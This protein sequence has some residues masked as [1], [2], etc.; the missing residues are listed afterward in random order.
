MT[1]ENLEINKKLAELCSRPDLVIPHWTFGWHNIDFDRP[2]PLGMEPFQFDDE[3]PYVK[4][5]G[6]LAHPKHNYARWWATEEQSREIKRLCEEL[7]RDSSQVN[8]EKLFGYLQRCKPT[9]IESVQDQ[10]SQE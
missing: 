1:P 3:Q 10:S 5:V 4:S 7:V 6:F 2:I 9:E 8:S